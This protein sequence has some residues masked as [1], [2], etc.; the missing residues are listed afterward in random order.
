MSKTGKFVLES[1]SVDCIIILYAAKL[2]VSITADQMIRFWDYDITDSKPSVFSLYGDHD[3]L[4]SL[5]AIATTE[6][7]KY[8]VTGDTAGCIKKW[9]ISKFKFGEHMTSDCIVE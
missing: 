6:C 4:D 7:N 8:L 3:K 9:D 5:T 1:K 2:I